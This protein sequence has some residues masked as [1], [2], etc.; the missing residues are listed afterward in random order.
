M[1]LKVKKKSRL[2]FSIWVV[3]SII[4]V[5]TIISAVLTF[6]HFQRQKE[7]AVELMAA[8]GATLIRSFE[9]GFRS[10]VTI[11]DNNF[12][13]QKLLM[14][15]AQQPD[16]DYIIITDSKNNILADSDPS[17]IGEKYGLDLNTA[18]TMQARNIQWRQV[19]NPDGADTF[20]VY[21]GFFPTDKH[22]E[23]KI[24]SSEKSADRK[25]DNLIIYVGFNMEAIEKAG[26]ED[27]RNT[28]II[29]LILLLIGSSVIVSLF[30]MQAYRQAHTSLSRITVF[31]E[32][33]VKNMPIGLIAFDASG[34][35]ALCNEKAGAILDVVCRDVIGRQAGSILPAPLQQ[36]LDELPQHSGQME[37]DMQISSGQAEVK[38]LEVVAAGLTEN[39][40]AA[41]RIM[42]F[43]DVTEI[44]QLENEVA[45]SRHLNSLGSLAA[46]V[47]H[48]IRNPLSSIK[49]FA[50]Y[51]KER[52]SGN[53][54]DEQTAD[55][56]I[57]EVERL[58]RVI[59]QLIEFARPLELKLEKVQ[60]P[61]LINHALALVNTEAQKK[62]IVITVDIAPDL[63]AL[64][65]DP[66]K[67][68][69]VLLN[70][71]LNSLAAMKEGGNIC[72]NLGSQKNGIS[73]LI[74]DT[75]SGIEQADLPRIYDPY[76]TSKPAGSGLGLAVVQ[77]IME[78]HGGTIKIQ[79][80]IAKGT[81]VSLNFPLSPKH[82]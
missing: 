3:I 1:K 41:G 56:M 48:E 31:S 72:I 35:I 66:D 63:P 76:F 14:E 6:S 28:I 13:L 22:R 68:K 37:K 74:S 32:A 67:I 46:G 7:Q 44:R 77:K 16:I 33:L 17:M 10:P 61:D 55:I 81:I 24:S 18:K 52:L 71:L 51:F 36:I 50:V 21:R 80:V 40:A 27:T 8:K 53:A 20:E 73:I 57:A 64:E 59:S 60:L 29:A 54:E 39:R 79:S 9:A 11:R 5:I 30:L 2:E 47:A 58:N 65:V 49:G 42:L 23:E 34:H 4:A 45:K 19:A 26:A 75:G 69:Q 15:T 43:R 78:A 12:Q 62:K 25:I 38:I 82:K 70:I